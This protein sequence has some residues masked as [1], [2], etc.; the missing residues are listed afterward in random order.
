[1]KK[2]NDS[3]PDI[4][5]HTRCRLTAIYLHPHWQLY[6]DVV[7]KV[8]ASVSAEGTVIRAEVTGSIQVRC[9]LPG[10]PTLALALNTSLSTLPQEGVYTFVNG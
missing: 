1:M 9:F 5:V 3:I 4:F 2:L 6:V 7:E 8:W 10:N